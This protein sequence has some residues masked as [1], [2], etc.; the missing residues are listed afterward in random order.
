MKELSSSQFVGITAIISAALYILSIIGLQYYISSDLNQVP[1]F[2]QNM[3]DNHSMMLIYGWPGFIATILILPLVFYIYL[4]NAKSFYGRNVLTV[5]LIGLSFI[6]IAYL[7]HLALTYFYAPSLLTMDENSKVVTSYIFK[8]LI[9]LQDMFWLGGDLLAFMGIALLTAANKRNLKFPGWL[10]GFGI[11]ACILASL[12]SFSFIPAFKKV[13]GLS[14]L[15]IGGF[16]LFTIWEIIIGIYL[17]KKKQ[18]VQT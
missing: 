2:A 15:F 9:G 18:S 16:A 10:V 7:F 11:L 17:L 12:G 14:F 8:N 3:V 6:M 4:K 1:A 5:T 13:P